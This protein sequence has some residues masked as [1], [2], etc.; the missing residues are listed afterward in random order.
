MQEDNLKSWFINYIKHKDII[1]R[2]ITKIDE[3]EKN[4]VITNKDETIE[5]AIINE[6]I[7]SFIDILKAFKPK[8]RIYIVCLN[9]KKNIAQIIKDWDKSI[10]FKLLTVSFVNMNST[11]EHKWVI[12]PYI[13]DTITDKSALKQGIMSI[14]SNVDLC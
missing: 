14:S 7:S 13:H 1:L 11:T 2:K 6:D 4:V 10:A 5:T 3:K 12:K 8:D 9:T